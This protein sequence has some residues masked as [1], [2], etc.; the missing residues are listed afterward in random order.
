MKIALYRG[1]VAAALM[2]PL[3]DAAHAAD[4]F[5]VCN[6]T[7]HTMSVSIGYLD[8][9]RGWTSEGWWKAAPGGCTD[10]LFRGD[11]KTL[12]YYAMNADDVVWGGEPSVGVMFCLSFKAYK[13][14][15]ESHRVT[16]NT[17]D[18]K[19][20]GLVMRSF[21]KVRVDGPVVMSLRSDQA[22]PLVTAAPPSGVKNPAGSPQPPS[23]ACQRYPNLC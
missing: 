19:K 22:T 2:L 13:D 23:S 3:R 8:A 10:N 14:H 6:M 4:S 9:R 17:Y 20:A 12:Y 1:L 16:E 11:N 5:I 7:A 18:C 15:W 21:R